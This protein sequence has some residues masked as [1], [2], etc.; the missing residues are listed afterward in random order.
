MTQTE[1]LDKMEKSMHLQNAD[2]E[3]A[4]QILNAVEGMSIWEARE[5]LQRCIGSFELMDIRYRCSF[6]PTTS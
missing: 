5:L 6:G 3:R 4:S 1:L 2:R